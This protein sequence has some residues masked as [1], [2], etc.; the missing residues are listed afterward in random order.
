MMNCLRVREMGTPGPL[1][2]FSDGRGLTH[3]RFVDSVWDGLKKA[4]ID[5]K[6]YSGYSFR[7]GAATTAA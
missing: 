2:H 7:I 6:N 4:G 1:F 5:D 3:K